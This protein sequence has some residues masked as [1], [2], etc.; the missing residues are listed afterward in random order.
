M[1]FYNSPNFPDDISYGSKGGPKF[2]TTII[3]LKSGHEQRNIN[4]LYPLHMYDVSYG[5]KTQAQ[6][7]SLRTFFMG[8]FGQAHTFRFKDWHDYTTHTD[9]VSTHAYD[10]AIVSAISSTVAQ[11]RI[12]KP[13]DTGTA[14][15]RR[16]INKP[17]AATV[18][19]GFLGAEL[20]SGRYSVNASSG[21]VSI[22]GASSTIGTITQAVSAV[23]SVT[24]T[25]G[26]DTGDTVYI[27]NVNGMTEINDARYTVTDIDTRHFSLNVNST[28]FTAYTSGGD[29]VEYPVTAEQSSITAGCQFDVQCRFDSDVFD[30]VHDDF[31]ITQLQIQVVEVREE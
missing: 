26:F 30:P 4:W 5:V 21:V 18:S 6:M 13:Y 1:T 29:A 31:D 28:G 10:D 19:V 2:S 16:D 14:V 25:H 22:N 27:R 20:P 15:L 11:Y 7:A 12:V 17:V 9:G 23:V 3:Q 24:A 8:M